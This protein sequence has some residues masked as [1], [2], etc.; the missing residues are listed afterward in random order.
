M[1]RSIR[2]TPAFACA[3]ALLLLARVAQADLSPCKLL[4]ASDVQGALGGQWQVWQ[5]L[6]SDEVCAFQS[7]PTSVIS[8]TLA[9]DPMGAATML[10]LR[11]AGAADK[12]KSVAGLGEAAFAMATP[13]A[14]VVLFGKGDTVVQLEVSFAASQDPA[15]AEKLAQA[16]Y[17]RMP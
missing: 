3:A 14:N 4:T 1:S 5:D 7:S 15:I 11:R 2:R 13:S 9:S 16:A 10:E 12:A 17:A 8:L 6:K